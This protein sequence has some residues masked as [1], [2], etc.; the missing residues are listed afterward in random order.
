MLVFFF[1]LCQVLGKGEWVLKGELEIIESCLIEPR[2]PTGSLMDIDAIV[3][4]PWMYRSPVYLWLCRGPTR[5]HHDSSLHRRDYHEVDEASASKALKFLR[6][7]SPQEEIGARKKR[8]N[9]PRAG[10]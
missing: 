3:H 8:E 1:Y 9:S 2:E 5:S 7:K 4:V 6:N 10:K